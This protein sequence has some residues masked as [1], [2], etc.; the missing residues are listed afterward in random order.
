MNNKVFISFALENEMLALKII[1][2]LH[3]ESIAL[4][5]AASISAKIIS[6]E[7]QITNAYAVIVLF[8][9]EA[10]TSPKFEKEVFLS[11]YSNKNIVVLKYTKTNFNHQQKIIFA[12]ATIIDVTEISIDIAFE[13]LCSEIETLRYIACPPLSFARLLFC[14]FRF[15][16]FYVQANFLPP[17]IACL[18]TCLPP[19]YRESEVPGM[20]PREILFNTKGSFVGMI[21]SLFAGMSYTHLSLYAPSELTR[22]EDM[23]V[24]VFFHKKRKTMKVIIL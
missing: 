13:K 21:G 7:Q 24:Q 15:I 18:P 14:R 3:E 23:L 20:V 17:P 4:D 5:F 8:T 22:G 6:V 10:L 16:F 12:D 19:Q 1:N 9:D 11:S 2:K